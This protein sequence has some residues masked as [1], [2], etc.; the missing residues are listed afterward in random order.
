V[1]VHVI[2]L[3]RQRPVSEF[4]GLLDGAAIVARNASAAQY[5]L[6]GE[7]KLDATLD[8]VFNSLP[9]G[10]ICD[11]VLKRIAEFSKDTGRCVYLVPE[12]GALGD[13]TVAAL[14]SEFDVN[15]VPGQFGIDRP[16]GSAQIVDALE[17]ARAEVQ[18]PFDAGLASVDHSRPLIVA[19]LT[20]RMVVPLAER[21]LSR[22]YG[23]RIALDGAPSTLVL[24]APAEL[25]ESS[26]LA[27]LEQVVARLRAPDGCPWDREQTFASVYPLMLEECEELREALQ[28][29]S[30]EEAADEL[31]DVL[32]HVAMIAQIAREAGMFGLEDVLRAN[33]SKLIRRHPHVFSDATVT[34]MD[35]IYTIWR[36]AKA[37]EQAAKQGAGA[38]AWEG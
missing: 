13:A 27:S 3:G 9:A 37:A 12:S 30:G 17:L 22:V 33:T 31:G 16:L 7:R 20:G 34:S 4:T 6:A 15:F 36:D 26:S 25:G 8:D 29:G 24:D 14:A 19:N 32:V 2:G 35:D 11:C 5:W 1:A 23:R 38:A 21:R 18:F 28:V 10:D